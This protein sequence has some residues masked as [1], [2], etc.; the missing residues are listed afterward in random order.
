MSRHES[1]ML[2]GSEEYNRCGWK[3]RKETVYTKPMEGDML[4]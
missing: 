1:V 4:Q 3:Q 2:K